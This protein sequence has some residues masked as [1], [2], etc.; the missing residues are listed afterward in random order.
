MYNY[1]NIFKAHSI[2]KMYYTSIFFL[3]KIY[4]WYTKKNSYKILNT[5]FNI[6]IEIN[7]IIIIQICV[8]NEIKY[9]EYFSFYL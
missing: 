1:K 4:N 7:L 6:N 8:T 2:M 9:T 5:M 3:I